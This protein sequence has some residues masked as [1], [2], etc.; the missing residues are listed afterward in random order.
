MRPQRTY[1]QSR[2]E[3]CFVPVSL[4]RTGNDIHPR[5]VR[6]LSQ[7]CKLAQKCYTTKAPL[8]QS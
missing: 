4:D 3:F 6:F 2:E 5:K 7:I 8:E 1:Q